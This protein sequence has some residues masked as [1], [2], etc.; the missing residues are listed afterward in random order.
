MLAPALPSTEF[1]ARNYH[2]SSDNFAESDGIMVFCFIAEEH[3]V[4]GF[5]EDAECR[6]LPLAARESF[7]ATQQP[8]LQGAF[9]R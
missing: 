6:R 8:Q 1:S 9:L 7:L 3:S 2:Y 5:G 4:I